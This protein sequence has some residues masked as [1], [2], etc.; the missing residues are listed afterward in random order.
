MVHYLSKVLSAL[1]WSFVIFA[2]SGLLIG[3]YNILLNLIIVI[4]VLLCYLIG[5]AYYILDNIKGDSTPT[6]NKNQV[7]SP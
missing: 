1:L 6:E 7:Q 3:F 2:V 5:M 4:I